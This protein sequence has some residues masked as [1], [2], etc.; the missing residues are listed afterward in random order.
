MIKYYLDESNGWRV[1]ISQMEETLKN[2]RDMG[3]NVRAIFVTNPGNPT[4]HVLSRKDIED[5]IILAYEN[6]LVILADEVN[7]DSIYTDARFIS[8]RKVLIEMGD[9]FNKLVELIS[10]NSTANA[11]MGEC[12]LKAGYMEAINLDKYVAEV[13]HKLKSMEECSGTLG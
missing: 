8:F 13:L 4:G 12:G 7:Q 1:N 2:A 3:V 9:P 10:F 11:L 5:I 6:G